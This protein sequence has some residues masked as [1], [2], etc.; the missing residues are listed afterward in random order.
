M[1]WIRILVRMYNMHYQV[2]LGYFS[3]AP[4]RARL[5]RLSPAVAIVAKRVVYHLAVKRSSGNLDECEKRS[6]GLRHFCWYV[7]LSIGRDK[8]DCYMYLRITR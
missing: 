8:N 4:A 2:F 7:D 5:Y 6:K 3:S 1:D